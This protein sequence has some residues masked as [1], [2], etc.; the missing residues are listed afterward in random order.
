[1]APLPPLGVFIYNDNKYNKLIITLL[2]LP[3]I[4]NS[5]LTEIA[6]KCR[7]ELVIFS[8][9]RRNNFAFY[10]KFR[11]IDEPEFGYDQR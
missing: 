6:K 3:D 11:G 10:T 9:D 8:G 4:L 1:V 7:F 2:F 5:S